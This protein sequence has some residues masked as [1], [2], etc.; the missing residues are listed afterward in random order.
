MMKAV[1]LR[2][3]IAIDKAG[4]PILLSVSQHGLSEVW[5]WAPEIGIQMWRTGDGIREK[6]ESVTEIGFAQ[7]GLAHFAGP[8]HWN[9]PD[10]LEVGN[11]GLNADE[12]KTQMSLW[13]LLAA[14]LLAGNDPSITTPE[15]LTILDN[16]EAIRI[17]QDPAGHQGD[18]VWAQGPVEIWARDLA[19]GSKAVGL[20]NRNAGAS[21][22]R[23]D[24][25]LIGWKVTGPVR[26]VWEGSTLPYLS[27][28]EVSCAEA[29]RC[30]ASAGTGWRSVDQS[31][32]NSKGIRRRRTLMRHQG[33]AFSLRTVLRSVALYIGALILTAPL[34]AQ[35][36]EIAGT[37]T[38]ASGALV[39]HAHVT[40]HDIDTNVVTSLVTNAGGSY[41][42][43]VLPPGRYSVLAEAS[44]FQSTEKTGITL[45]VD[46]P[47]RVDFKLFLGPSNQAVTV[48]DSDLTQ[49]NNAEMATEISGM[50]YLELPLEQVG[51]IR[52]PTSFVYLAPGVQG[53]LQLNGQEYTG[54]TNVI[55]VHGSNIW[56][57]ELL[58]DGIPGAKPALSVTTPNPL[59]QSMQCVSSST[60]DN[61]WHPPT[62]TS[63]A[64]L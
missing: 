7:A 27:I 62:R 60:V 35:T 14:P 54:A 8:G 32:S 61:N 44:G 24:L 41:D 26:D 23:L 6:Y 31:C 5:T 13:S 40:I 59:R 52:S 22:V 4:R 43:P 58:V 46:T 15:M 45:F 47:A 53:N 48:T 3:H 34:Y 12:A 49:E 16:H 33:L 56:N 51:R 11:Q 25:S 39:Q 37:V 29:R 63:S 21:W 42:A 30:L 17:D 1:F 9:D 18:R 38:D 28:A 2:M 10:M 20:F 57:T 19:D 64:Q 55:A 36:A 50:Q